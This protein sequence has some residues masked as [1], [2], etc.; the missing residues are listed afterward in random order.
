MI[1]EKRIEVYVE[2]FR[3]GLHLIREEQA[4]ELAGTMIVM[5]DKNIEDFNKGFIESFLSIKKK[6]QNGD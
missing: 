4:K 2:F 6:I 3:N 1:D 5:I